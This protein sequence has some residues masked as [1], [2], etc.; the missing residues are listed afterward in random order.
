MRVHD[1]LGNQEDTQALTVD[2]SSRWGDVSET[3][4]LEGRIFSRRYLLGKELGEGGM[5]TVY[6]ATDLRTGGP[7][8]V[9]VVRPSLTSD[10]SYIE[11]LKRE[12]QA[13]A[14]VD[15]PRV[16]RII[17]LS[18]EE[19]IT[20]FVMEYVNGRTLAERLKSG[21][22]TMRQALYVARELAYALDAIHAKGIIHRDL[23]PQNIKVDPGGAV[24]L[25]D[26]GIARDLKQPGVTS[27]GLFVG[28]PIYAAP[29]RI[30]GKNDIR[31]DIYA[32][33]AILFEMLM[34]HPPFT[35]TS[36]MA[37]LHKHAT[38]PVPPL[39]PTIPELVQQVVLRCLAKRPEDRYQTPRALIEALTAAIAEVG[40]TAEV[41]RMG[42]GTPESV[43]GGATAPYP[44]PSTGDPR[45]QLPGS[46]PLTSPFLQPQAT[47][48]PGASSAASSGFGSERT[49]LLL[50]ASA[51]AG[52][53]LFVLA[54]LLLLARVI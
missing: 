26:F 3:E 11:R 53:M 48:Q 30:D 5:G 24:K 21:P 32:V 9:K 40:G 29:E 49:R 46:V 14:A 17:D 12:A 13:A 54:L 50:Y 28:S 34:G 10:P 7:V 51:G 18:I 1:D 52:A 16:V 33:G 4:T 45:G 42:L 2:S 22:L 15:S 27:V 36:P 38:E 44:G 25:L 37:V 41:R 8:A 47:A 6:Q 20:Y 43:P 39:P 35:G 19:G 23:K 31:G